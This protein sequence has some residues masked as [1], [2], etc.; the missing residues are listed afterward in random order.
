MST[1]FDPDFY[2]P[3]VKDLIEDEGRRRE[4]YDDATGQPIRAPKGHVTIGV[5]R[6]LEAKPLSDDIIYALLREDIHDAYHDCLAIYGEGF[7]DLDDV[8]KRALVNMSFNL[9]RTTLL[10]FKR[11]N[12]AVKK[13]DWDTA[14]KNAL[15]SK[16]A[17]QVKGR[18]H[19]IAYR[20]RS[21]N[22]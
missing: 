22:G 16:W 11:F 8:R 17:T 21:G 1:Y 9:G 19:R 5:G 12:E 10:K 3:L 7:E 4:P 2:L 18:S 14:A 6:N 20:I 13:R 15:E